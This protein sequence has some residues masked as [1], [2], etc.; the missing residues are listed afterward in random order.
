M[1]I[2][3]TVTEALSPK[4]RSLDIAERLSAIEA[5]KE[6]AEGAARVDREAVRRAVVAGTDPSGAEDSATAHEAKA[7]TLAARAGTL[8][9]ELARVK[10]EEEASA[11]ASAIESARADLAA[12][13][14]AMTKAEE[15]CISALTALSQSLADR[16]DA[17]SGLN[18]VERTLARLG[19]ESDA[20]PFYVSRIEEAARLKLGGGFHRFDIVVPRPVNDA[21]SP[22]AAMREAASA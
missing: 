7:R 19:I 4:A 9:A 1:N 17:V 15:K 13:V 18:D 14:K 3:K 20:P 2:V 22:L 8:R 10:A 11:K 6:S 5:A 12:K 21:A 16:E